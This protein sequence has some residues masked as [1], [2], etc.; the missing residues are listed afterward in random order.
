M[1]EQV[2]QLESTAPFAEIQVEI[3]EPAPEPEEIAFA[4]QPEVIEEVIGEQAAPKQKPKRGKR[5]SSPRTKRPGKSKAR[6]AK[7]KSKDEGISKA[8]SN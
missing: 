4:A 6:S 8:S 2:S 3:A 7:E 5:I 1:P